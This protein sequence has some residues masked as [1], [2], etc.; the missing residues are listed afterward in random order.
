MALPAKSA[1]GWMRE[2]LPH[3]A[4]IVDEFR[5]VF[6]EESINDGLRESWRDGSFYAEDF[7]TG[8][9]IEAKLDEIVLLAGI[10]GDGVH[11]AR[12][13]QVPR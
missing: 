12:V 3:V 13:R 10:S 4:A 1:N 2:A 5:M 7:V 9:K 11:W 8:N 6:G